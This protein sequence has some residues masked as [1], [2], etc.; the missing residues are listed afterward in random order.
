MNDAEQIR[1]LLNVRIEALSRHDAVAANE[2]LDAAIVAFE[3]AGPL[4]VPAAQATDPSATQAWLDGFIE[5]PEVTLEELA[6][7]A[8]GSTAFCHSLNRLRGRP[9]DGQ[10]VDVM[11]RSTLGLRK[12]HGSWKIVH[13]HTS[14]P[15]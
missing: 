5:G 12:R 11:M 8:E 14:L 6:I 4:Q 1:N 2:M 13:A 7:H 9:A 10:E 3:L 15:R